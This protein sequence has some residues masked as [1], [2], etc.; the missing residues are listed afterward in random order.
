MRPRRAPEADRAMNT[1]PR[2]GLGYRQ[3]PVLMYHRL[4]A[5]T[6]GH[7][8]SLAVRRFRGQL[9]LLR[10]LGYRTIT[11]A[12]IA[13]HL[14]GGP[15]P[16]PRSVALTFDD[17]YL[18]TL[19]IALPL[20]LEF[21]FTAT[22]YIVA[23]GVGRR[24]DWTVPAPLMDWAG[25]RAWLDAGMA[26]GSHTVAHR[27]LTTLDEAAV[28]EEIAGSRARI[29]D[30]LGIPVPSFAYPY[31]RLDPRA[32]DAVAAAGYTDAVA[33]ADVLATPYA[34]SRVAGDRDSRARFA[35]GLLPAYPALRGLYRAA[36]R[37]AAA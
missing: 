6:G 35:L 27:D 21:G 2:L 16:P 12:A 11:P 4:T 29:E 33:G 15:A 24:S 36:V 8:R 13:A 25:V 1:R 5:R 3:A 7:P 37:P 31:N 30:R 34:L 28:R 18:D 20:L 9:A 17:G 10:A 26:V 14:R 19:T 22:C 32:L 23:G